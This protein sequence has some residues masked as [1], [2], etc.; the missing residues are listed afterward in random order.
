MFLHITTNI[1]AKKVVGKNQKEKIL[2]TSN[3]IQYK[4]YD[5]CTVEKK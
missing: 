1:T 3:K 2:Y 5:N 4:K